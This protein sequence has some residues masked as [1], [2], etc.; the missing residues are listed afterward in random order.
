MQLTSRFCKKNVDGTNGFQLDNCFLFNFTKFQTCKNANGIIQAT[1][2]IPPCN[3][4]HATLSNVYSKRALL[5]S[6]LD[7]VILIPLIVFFSPSYNN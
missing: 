2:L 5:F 1:V 7:L 3:V 4:G 6:N